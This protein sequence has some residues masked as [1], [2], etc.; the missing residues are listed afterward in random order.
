MSPHILAAPKIFRT[1]Q[2]LIE[3]QKLVAFFKRSPSCL[4]TNELSESLQEICVSSWLTL[5]LIATRHVEP[6]RGDHGDYAA[7]NA[8]LSQ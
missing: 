7:L 6:S 4:R 3:L 2:V 5:S 1:H 8:Q